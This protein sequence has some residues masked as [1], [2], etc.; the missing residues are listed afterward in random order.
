MIFLQDNILL[1]TLAVMALVLM[2]T[3]L[4]FYYIIPSRRKRKDAKR[5]GY[6]WREIDNY[7]IRIVIAIITI[8]ISF[9]S[10]IVP[11]FFNDTINV[12]S[13]APIELTDRIDAVSSNLIDVSAELNIIQRELEQRI[14]FVEELRR[15]AEIAEA[16][17][18]LSREQVDAIRN[19]LNVE[20]GR[21]ET[22]NFWTTFLTSF[23]FL[24]LGSIVT[25]FTPKIINKFTGS[26]PTPK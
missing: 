19:M 16:M 20:L 2:F 14:E 25:F 4:L 18:D 17:I 3:G 11:L 9:I 7:Y 26:K 6:S 12:P 5:T 23:F 1:I 13:N 21:N 15:E 24:I 8:I 22:R 10:A